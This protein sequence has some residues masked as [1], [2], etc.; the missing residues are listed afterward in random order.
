VAVHAIGNAGLEAA[1]GAF[2]A[3]A[4]RHPD[5]DHRFRVEHACLA[6][7]DQL[8]RLAG[9]GGVAVVQPGFLHHLGGQVEG[10]HFDDAV[11]LPFGDMQR[12]G[13]TMAASSDCPC[14][15]HEPLRTSAHG[16]S[17]R[18]SSGAV[19]DPGQAV[20]FEDWLWAYTAGAALA[21][22][23]EH[24]RGSIAPGLRA[25]L[26]VLEGELDAHQ[27]PVVAQT[28]VGGRQVHPV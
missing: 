21:G 7:A 25:D 11:W 14:T 28:W 24:E 1:L 26:V 6:S 18:T 13:L 15:F 22:G 8:R 3:T 9:L 2:E 20:S 10:V 4:R 27:P 17:R 19:L 12:A 23:Q 16:A 5:G